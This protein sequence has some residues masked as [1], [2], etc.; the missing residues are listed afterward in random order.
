MQSQ[1]ERGECEN[2]RTMTY[3]RLPTNTNNGTK[4][5]Y[6]FKDQKQFFQFNTSE[7]KKKIYKEQRE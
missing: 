4:K 1:K 6:N 5:V 3:I 7:W 2:K